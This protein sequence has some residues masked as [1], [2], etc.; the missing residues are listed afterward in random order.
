MNEGWN[1]ETVLLPSSKISS[2][3]ILTICIMWC[4]VPGTELD[5]G[6]RLQ[7]QFCLDDFLPH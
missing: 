2:F 1:V 7:N 6:Y 5:T 4:R 3:F